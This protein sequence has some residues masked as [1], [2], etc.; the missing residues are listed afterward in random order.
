MNGEDLFRGLNYVN[1]K[2]INEAETVTQLKGEKKILSL[3]R[4]VLIAALIAVLLMLVGCTVGYVSGW[5]AE[6]FAVRSDI[7]L[8][9]GQIDFIQENEQ[10][11][12][13]TRSGHDW[14]VE[15]RSTMHDGKTGY[16]LFSIT[17]PEETDLER[18]FAGQQKDINAPY[19]TPGNYSRR[20]SQRAIVIASTGFSD[21]E[22]NFYWSEHGHWEADNDGIPNTLNYVVEIRCEKLQPNKAQ[23]LEDPFGKD[24][25]FQAR[26]F[27]FTLEYEDQ[28]VRESIDAELAERGD[29]IIDG[30]DLKDL[31]KTD[32]LVEG[33][34]IFDVT[35]TE[36]V[37]ETLE[38]II[39]PVTVNAWVHHKTDN[40]TM[41]YDTTHGIEE[42][43]ITSF[44][45]S[46]MGAEVRY[47]QEEDV[48]GVFLEWEDDQGVFVVMKDGSQ[49]Q[50]NSNGTGY[51]WYSEIPIVL[52]DVD[53]VKL[54]DG[55]K[56]MVQN[57]S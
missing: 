20:A 56:L 51:T 13:E 16:I 35:F 47:Q 10:V 14:T 46:P 4:P 7:P 28:E 1:A 41:F 19:I 25:T 53:H 5:F 55:T 2:F 24:I 3:R 37:I 17:A 27:D 21:I 42:I 45:L 8:S 23:L 9:D 39:Q 44:V 30:E 15:L 34:W 48:I 18:Y 36:S 38:L 50:L 31:Y 6:L 43:Q 29:G 26:F 33:E 49:I 52:S 32:V 57:I 40:G 12:M 22:K 11:I 54:A